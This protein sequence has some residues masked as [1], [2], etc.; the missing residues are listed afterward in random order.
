MRS[1]VKITVFKEALKAAGGDQEAFICVYAPGW[2][3][4]FVYNEHYATDEEFVFVAAQTPWAGNVAQWS[5]PA[6]S[7][8]STIP[9]W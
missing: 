5:M 2:L 9:A 7:C 6:S 3:D 8:K 1:G 4:H